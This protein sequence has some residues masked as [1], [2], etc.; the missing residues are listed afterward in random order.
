MIFSDVVA[1]LLGEN[2]ESSF[3]LVVLLFQKSLLDKSSIVTCKAL[4]RQTR[5]PDKRRYLDAVLMVAH[6]AENV[7][8]DF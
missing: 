8:D 5:M 4:R 6:D 1:T 7:E 2:Y 3:L